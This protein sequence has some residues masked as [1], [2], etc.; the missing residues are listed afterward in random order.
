LQKAFNIFKNNTKPD[1]I[2]KKEKLSYSYENNIFIQ[3]IK[4]NKYKDI[5]IGD[6]K[7]NQILYKKN[8]LFWFVKIIKKFVKKMK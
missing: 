8:Y 4:N 7:I 6:Y 5:E 1:I 3:G 2:N